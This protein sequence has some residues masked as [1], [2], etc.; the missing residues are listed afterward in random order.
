MKKERT[1]ERSR[2]VRGKNAGRKKTGAKKQALKVQGLF[3][4]ISVGLE[5]YDIGC[6]GALGRV[7]NVELHLLAFGERLE[8][9]IL[10]VAEMHEHISACFAGNESK[11]FGIIEPLNRTCFHGELPPS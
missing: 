2:L 3:K 8:A 4:V 9:A 5:L 10:N 7:D 6:L 1:P 11:T